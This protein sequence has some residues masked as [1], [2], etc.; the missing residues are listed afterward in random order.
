MFK[1]NNAHIFLR[2]CSA[3]KQILMFKLFK[4]STQKKHTDYT[5]LGADLHAHL[6]PGIDDGS[7]DMETSMLL[8]N[9]L[10]ELGFKKLIATPHVISDRYPN[11]RDIILKKRDALSEYANKRG[12]PL[13]HFD[14]AAEYFIDESFA[15]LLQKEVL[16]TL[17]GNRVLVEMSFLQ[18]YPDLHQVLFDLQMKG[19]KPVLAHPERY[20]YYSTRE[21]FEQ[22]KQLGC[23]FQTNLLSLSGY[24]NPTVQTAARTLVQCGFIDFLG[25]DLHHVR[26][27]E[28]LQQALSHKLVLEA[29]NSQSLK[30]NSLL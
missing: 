24:Y 22:V 25:T 30:N 4:K 6:L 19:Y 15:A 14:V 27:A 1:K 16:L 8:I 23:E 7:P 18:P 29:L 10:Q 28:N 2:R 17:P 9:L 20:R 26:Q 13:D 11:T 5:V 3:A 21:D 12:V